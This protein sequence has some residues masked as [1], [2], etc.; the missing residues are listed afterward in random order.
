MFYFFPNSSHASLGELDGEGSGSPMEGRR[1]GSSTWPTPRTP[2]VSKFGQV[3]RPH[4]PKTWAFQISLWVTNGN[5]IN[6]P[7]LGMV[8]IPPIKMVIW[9]MVSYCFKMF[10]HVLPTLSQLVLAHLIP[11]LPNARRKDAMPGLGT[12]SPEALGVPPRDFLRR[13][14][15]SSSHAINRGKC[16]RD[17]PENWKL[18]E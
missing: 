15:T 4:L 8:T 2:T 1:R 7:W 11:V 6:H 14:S 9:G 18:W 16:T 17:V 12:Y 10:Y 5:T 13:R 3:S